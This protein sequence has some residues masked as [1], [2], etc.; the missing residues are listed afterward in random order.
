[1]CVRFLDSQ[2]QRKYQNPLMNFH[3]Q[4]GD[5]FSEHWLFHR[6]SWNLPKWWISFWSD[7]SWWSAGVMKL[8]HICTFSRYQNV[9]WMTGW[10]PCGWS[11]YLNFCSYSPKTWLLGM[12]MADPMISLWQCRVA[13]RSGWMMSDY[14]LSWINCRSI[15][16]IADLM[17]ASRSIPI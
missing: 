8:L 11:V 9:S 7:F 1:M 10:C 16:I 6:T 4:I 14:E 2:I 3:F 13:R 12:G 17:F 15:P 5:I